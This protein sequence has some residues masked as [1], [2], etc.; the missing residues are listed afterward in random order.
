M[1]K[2]FNKLGFN[3]IKYPVLLN[4]VPAGDK[5]HNIRIN[6]STFDDAVGFKRHSQYISKKFKPEE[7]NLLYWD[8]RYA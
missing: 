2:H 4:K 3:K 7:V 1:N 8:G 5:E 6:V